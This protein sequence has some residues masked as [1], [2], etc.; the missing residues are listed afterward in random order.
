MQEND[1]ENL[2]YLLS[3]HEIGERV[4]YDDREAS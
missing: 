1:Q 3:S 4:R 2:F